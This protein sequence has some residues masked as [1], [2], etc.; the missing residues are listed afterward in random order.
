MDFQGKLRKYLP[1]KVLWRLTAAGTDCC[2]SVDSLLRT[3]SSQQ[4]KNGQ[5]AKAWRVVLMKQVFPELTRPEGLQRLLT[6]FFT[7]FRLLEDDE[8]PPDAEDVA[9]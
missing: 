7:C 9:R 4:T 1:V 2:K 6:R 3:V 5:A 8:S